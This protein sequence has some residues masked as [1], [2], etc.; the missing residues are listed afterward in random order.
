MGLDEMVVREIECDLSPD[1]LL[2][3]QYPLIRIVIWNLQATWTAQEQAAAGGA[4]SVNWAQ[5]QQQI[6]EAYNQ[7]AQFTGVGGGSSGGG[8]G[9]GGNDPAADLAAMV[10]GMLENIASI[11]ERLAEEMPDIVTPI[12]EWFD[13]LIEVGEQVKAWKEQPGVKSFIKEFKDHVYPTL[14][15]FAEALEPVGALLDTI[16][17]IANVQAQEIGAVKTSMATYLTLLKSVTETIQAWVTDNNIAALAESFNENVR[18]ALE[19]WVRSVQPIS[20]LLSTAVAIMDSLATET[21]PVRTSVTTF[22]T[23]LKGA[24][25]SVAEWF[26]RDQGWAGFVDYYDKDLRQLIEKWV[27]VTKPIADL[28]GTAKNIMDDLAAKTEPV[29]TSVTT[30]LKYLKGAMLGVAEWFGKDPGWAG[31]LDYFE[32]DYKPHIEKWIEVTK[33]IAELFSIA[34]T[35]MDQL[36]EKAKPLQTTVAEVLQRIVDVMRAFKTWSDADLT[37][38]SL[39]DEWGKKIQPLVEKL[40]AS[41]KPIGDLFSVA[42]SV[43]DALAMKVP[44]DEDIF[45]GIVTVFRGLKRVVK[46]INDYYDWMSLMDPFPDMAQ[47]VKDWLDKVRD[48]IAPISNALSQAKSIFDALGQDVPTDEELFVG[49]VVVFRGLRRVVKTVED[50][51]NWMI[52]MEPW[53]KMDDATQKW[54][55]KTKE[56]IAPLSTLFSSVNAIFK[57]LGEKLPEA[58]TTVSAMLDAAKQVI[59][60]VVDAF[61]NADWSELFTALT[62]DVQAQMSTVAKAVGDI[63]S[64]IGGAVSALKSLGEKTP[65]FRNDKLLDLMGNMRTAI[66]TVLSVFKDKELDTERLDAIRQSAEAVRG[67]VNAMDGM[68]KA[69]KDINIPNAAKLQQLMTALAGGTFNGQHYEGIIPTLNGL[70]LISSSV[71]DS[72]ANLASAISALKLA[73]RDIND[74]RGVNIEGKGGLNEGLAA[75]QRIIDTLNAKA[76]TFGDGMRTALSYIVNMGQDEGQQTVHGLIT[77]FVEKVKTM[78]STLSAELDAV[79]KVL[80]PDGAFLTTIKGYDWSTPGS[81]LADPFKT[82]L[83]DKVNEAMSAVDSLLN[84]N[85]SPWA[86][87]WRGYDWNAVG[88]SIGQ[89]LLSGIKAGAASGTVTVQVNLQVSNPGGSF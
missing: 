75:V 52:R 43:F 89:S 70:P 15:K 64:I 82:G 41:I 46:T 68:A 33:P 61:K 29:R 1:S 31:F 51:Y 17:Q 3:F 13:A 69:I 76:I 18:P 12:Q 73:V 37:L 63:N 2:A 80:G 85:T 21:Q 35:I 45:A 40:L 56:A 88:Q 50:Y 65:A 66:D 48:T 42:K 60:D 20:E 7:A 14:Q 62:E 26:G 58:K 10:D 22:L 49:V 39:V 71:S 53:P 67:T 23:Y 77:E 54:L 34:K 44:S 47:A 74:L 79:L 83:V 8:G 9:G 4:G 25:M 28:L 36:G 11:R 84:P 87:T 16:V 38:P 86:A 55:D 6:Q 72:F 19:K 24:M 27:E 59:S 81:D 32:R 30:F 57:A 78:A 5:Y